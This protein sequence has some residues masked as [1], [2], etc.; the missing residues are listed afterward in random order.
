MAKINTDERVIEYAKD[1]KVCA[2]KLTERLP[3]TVV[4]IAAA[5]NLH[6]VM[7][8]RWRQEYREGKLI[9]PPTRRITMSLD[10]KSPSK[11]SP[12]QLSENDRLRKENARLK[13]EVSLLKKWQGYLAEVR[14]NDSDSSSDS[15]QS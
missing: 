1:F 3:V 9:A 10:K 8:Y 14:R 12:K 2:V 11:P 6:P 13:K 4:E 7:V 5:L 15:D